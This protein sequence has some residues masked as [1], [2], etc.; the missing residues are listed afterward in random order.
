MTLTILSSIC[1]TFCRTPLNLCL[2]DFFSWLDRGYVFL[3]GRLQRSSDICITSYQRYMSC[4]WLI[5][6]DVNLDHPAN[7]VLASF[8]H[9]VVLSTFLSI[10]YSLFGRQSPSTAGKGILLPAGG[11][12]YINYLE[13]HCM[14]HLS[15]FHLLIQS[16]I[17]ISLDFWIFILYSGDNPVLFQ[18]FVAPVPALLVQVASSEC[19][20]DTPPL[21]VCD[22]IED[23]LS[24]WHYKECQAIF[25]RI[26]HFSKEPW[27]LLL[28]N[29]IRN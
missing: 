22:F 8:L 19:P 24:F 15:I 29:G 1:Q 5:I 17:Y 26:S 13:F 2:P 7:V 4:R 23:I 16:F 6:A 27:F 10:L 20:L 18:Y 3:R 21:Q 12:I 28:K 25:Y 9:Q 11:N 14:G